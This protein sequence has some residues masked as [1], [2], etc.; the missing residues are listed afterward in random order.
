MKEI[1]LTG[2]PVRDLQLMLNLLSLKYPDLP[3]LTA[4]G[5]F[6]ERTLEAVM[7]FQRDHFPPVTGVVDSGTWYAITAAVQNMIA[8]Q[9]FPTALRALPSGSYT[10][11][12]GQQ[13]EPLLLAQAIL[14]SLTRSVDNFE[15]ALMDGINSGATQ[16]NLR[17]IQNLSGLPETG[18]LDRQTWSFL[19][20][21]YHIFVTRGGLDV[22]SP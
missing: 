16:R 18:I 6:G 8:Q 21:L 9:G 14:S 7:L 4:D 11:E 20:R 3:R 2:L 1:N 17:T 22:F 10:V 5:V 15:T 13:G 12:P 19:V